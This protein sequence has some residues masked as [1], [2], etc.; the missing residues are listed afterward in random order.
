MPD[1]QQQNGQQSGQQRGKPR[2]IRKQE[3][4]REQRSGSDQSDVDR[5]LQDIEASALAAADGVTE[6][7]RFV[8]AS[9]R[10]HGDKLAMVLD[11]VNREHDATRKALEHTQQV[12]RI[13]AL[14]PKVVPRVRKL[15]DELDRKGTNDVGAAS[16]VVGRRVPVGGGAGLFLLA[17]A[18]GVVTWAALIFG[19][20]WR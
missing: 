6:L 12:L 4:K 15:L 10:E 2:E 13:V 1:E 8:Q 20:V 16:A 9:Q 5:V 3:P 14:D 7:A 19:E 11:A 18:V 17:V